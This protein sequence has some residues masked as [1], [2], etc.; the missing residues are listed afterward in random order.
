MIPLRRGD[1]DR[2][3]LRRRLWPLVLAFVGILVAGSFGY[4]VIEQMT[5]I[6]ALYM[7]VITLTTVGFGEVQELSPT[8]RVFTTVLIVVGV[9]T[10]GY[11]AATIVEYLVSGHLQAH[12]AQRRRNQALASLNGHDLVCGYGR[13]GREIAAELHEAGHRVLVIDVD[14]ERCER[15]EADGHICVRGDAASTEVIAEAQ[16]A[17]AGAV[18]IATGSDAQNVYAT[19]AAHVMAPNVP[20]IARAS[21]MEAI[22]RLRAAGATRVFSPHAEGA[23]TM[24]SFVLRPRVTD[25][26]A[27][28]L[29]PRSG[30]LTIEEVPITHDSPFAGRTIRD[31]DADHH[32]SMREVSVLA[33]VRADGVSLVPT[34]SAQID[35]GDVMIL[36]GRPENVTRAMSAGGVGVSAASAT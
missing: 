4:I 11:T 2:R 7:T 3:Y 30:T 9:S 29:D 35:P 22:E 16:L 6:D 5:G 18:L 32:E 14:A 10:L 27:E 20:I 13:V 31:I 24:A 34:G 26:L 1:S 36:V 19:L 23:A 17:R 12:F 25:I 15:A 21:S 33:I 8:G 28:L